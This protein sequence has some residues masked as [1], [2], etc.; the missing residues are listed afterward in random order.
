M[1][2]IET[3]HGGLNLRDAPIAFKDGELSDDL[4]CEFGVLGQV[5]PMREGLLTWTLVATIV[6]AKIAYVAQTA[7][8][9]TTHSDGL[10][11][12]SVES[13]YVATT[14]IDASF[15]G[16]FCV[17][18]IND[19]YFVL[20]NG[21]ESIKW[22][23][24]WSAAYQWGLNTPPAPTSA[25]SSASSK[26]IDDFED[27]TYWVQAGG[28]GSGALAADLTVYTEGTQSMKLTC[29]ENTICT[30][31]FDT[32][33]DLTEV[34]AGVGIGNNAYIGIDYYAYDLRYVKRITLKMSCAADAGFDKDYFVYAIPLDQAENQ[35]ILKNTYGQASLQLHSFFD[36]YYDSLPVYSSAD[37][38]RGPNVS[39]SP[40]SYQTVTTSD[41][42]TIR[43][44]TIQRVTSTPDEPGTVIDYYTVKAPE[45]AT[46]A[47]T[48]TGSWTQL[49]IPVELWQRVGATS[50]RGWDT[51]TALRIELEAQTSTANV[52]FD[53]WRLVRGQTVGT[54]YFAVAYENEL[55]NYGPYSDFSEAIETAGEAI[56][57]S[58]L[59]PDTDSQTTAR[60]LLVMGGSLTDFFVVTIDDNTSTTYEY[61]LD[62][63]SLTEIETRFNNRPPPAC[64]DMVESHGRIFLVGVENYP[65]HMAYS[66]ELFF[67]AFPYVNYQKIAGGEDLYQIAKLGDYVAV[68]GKHREHLFLLTSG[69]PSTWSHRPG[70]REGA[71]TQRL[72]LELEGSQQVYASKK[73]LYTSSLGG[74]D[75]FFLEKVNNAI[76]DMDDVI[77]AMA[78]KKAYLYFQKDGTNK[79][80]RIDF[81]HGYPLAHFVE[82]MAPS[83]IFAD[84]I[85]GKVYYTSGANIYEFDAGSDPLPT[86]LVI[87]LYCK[88]KQV[89][90]W[91]RLVYQLDDGPLTLTMEKDGTAV[92]SSISLADAVGE[93]DQQSLPLGTSARLLEL[94]LQSTTQDFTLTLP[95]EIVETPI[96]S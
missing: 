15:T 43:L 73:G 3:L 18:P 53:N 67:E 28:G 81:T 24:T 21:T 44:V 27:L 93:A 63:T 26:T 2:L 74:G 25:K 64:L 78:G 42:R 89:K 1:C 33:L 6:D 91:V 16:T 9:F 31:T 59:T 94:T 56:T 29:S 85:L 20:S 36:A 66:D 88:T 8:L 77:G 47:K 68:R 22:K 58:G 38:Q 51:I 35:A 52:S 48:E 5:T 76:D 60:R 82:D 70:A 10:R 84:K 54:Y 30:G 86:K 55:G 95:W 13:G 83:A 40:Q 75:G 4:G 19:E 34:S 49:K 45:E 14:V 79:V 12:T 46:Q 65:H 61:D 69:D 17:L 57:I 41:G 71:V 50:G 72:L 39:T 7:Y 87:P 23:P 92:S 37:I 96:A 11:V 80:M 90:D 32:T 62:D